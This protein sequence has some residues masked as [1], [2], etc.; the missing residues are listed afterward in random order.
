LRDA[1]LPVVDLLED[2]LDAA[3][4]GRPHAVLDPAWP[5]PLREAAHRQ[6]REAL[7]ERRVTGGDLVLF[8]SGSTGAPRGVVRTADSW[9]ASL[10]PLTDLT[11][12]GGQDVVWLPGP[13]SSSLFLHGGFHARHVGAAVVTGRRPPAE[14]TAVHLV[15]A[16]LRD[17]LD[18]ADEGALPRLRTV[19]CA[20]DSLPAVLREHAAARGWRVLEYYGAAELSFVAWRDDDGRFRPFPGAEVRVADGVLWASSPYL[21]RG[22]LDPADAGPLRRDGRW[23]TVGDLADGDGAGVH[24]RG[25]AESAVTTGG[26]TVVAEEV[27]QV[28]AGADGVDEAGVVGLPHPDLGSVLA[29]VLVPSAGSDPATARAVAAVATRALPAP[30][31]P[32]RWFTADRLPRTGAG[33][34]DRAALAEHVRSGVARPLP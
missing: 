15:P 20:G 27:E 18:A 8:T 28:L 25:R 16:L 26:H 7:A 12:L 14:A 30:A 29:A 5:A 13:L 6:L 23:A 34:L 4:A 3:A 33:K 9:R 31:R 19:V 2:L 32:R 17:A 24:V 1:T 10:A 22:Y 11:G 21:A